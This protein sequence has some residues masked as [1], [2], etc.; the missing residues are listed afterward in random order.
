MAGTEE[1]KA[2]S[3]AEP[4]A[5]R[6][7][8]KLAHR[9]W[10]G[11]VAGLAAVA[12]LAAASCLATIRYSRATGWVT[13]AHLALDRLYDLRLATAL[14]DRHTA[15]FVISGDDSHLAPRAAAQTRILEN[16]AELRDLAR[17]NR[18]V[19]GLLDALAPAIQARIDLDDSLVTS[20]RSHGEEAAAEA[21]RSDRARRVGETLDDRLMLIANAERR[22]ADTHISAEL[23]IGR[24]N[25]IVII[26]GCA[27]ALAAIGS[28]GRFISSALAMLHA[29]I[30]DETNGRE[31]LRRLNETLEERVAE[32][33]AAAEQRALELARSQ[34]ALYRQT[35]LLQSLL[36]SMADAV[37]VCDKQMKLVEINP[38]AERLLGREIRNL[39]LDQWATL[40][41]FLHEENG[42][43]VPYNQWPLVRATRGEDQ[44]AVWLVRIAD[45]MRWLEGSSGPIRDDNGAILGAAIVFRDIT[46]R[47][48][49]AAELRQ[50][51]DLALESARLRS[52]FLTNMSHEIRTPLNGIIGMTQLLLDTK[53]D[54]DQR[55]QLQT[56]WSSG[57]L[58]L[59][60]V[61][62]VLDFSKLAAGKV[63]LEQTPFNLYETVETTVETFAQRAQSQN[64]ELI[65]AI[66]PD[67]PRDAL[68]DARALTQILTNL[69]SNGIKFT[70]SGEVV[71]EVSP[72]ESSDLPGA[73]RF[74]V[75]D[76]GIGIAADARERLF[77]PFSQADGSTSRKFGGSGLGLAITARL[78]EA[79]GGRVNFESELGVGS[80]FTFTIS[81]VARPE[82]APRT[83]TADGLGGLSILLAEANATTRQVLSAR[84]QAWKMKVEAVASHDE[85]LEAIR[86]RLAAGDPYNFIL[87]DAAVLPVDGD[88]L[89]TVMRVALE[90]AR[91][92]ILMMG[93]AAAIRAIDEHEKPVG[94]VDAWIRKPVAPS[95]LCERLQALAPRDERALAE[96]QLT[97][98]LA[99]TQRNGAVLDPKPVRLLVIED[100]PVNLKLALMQ[101]KKLGYH[102]SGA[103]SAREGL[104]LLATKCFP[105]VLM[106]CEM[107]EI[108][109]YAATREIR[110]TEAGTRRTILIAM[111][112]HAIEGARDKC[113]EAG[114]D[115][116][117][118]KPVTLETLRAALERWTP[119]IKHTA[120]DALPLISFDDRESLDPAVLADIRELSSSEDGDA[121]AELVTLFLEDLPPR[122]EKLAAAI[123]DA[124]LD[125]ARAVAHSLKSACNSMGAVRLAAICDQAETSA[126][127]GDSAVVSAVLAQAR[128]EAD[129]VRTLLEAERQRSAA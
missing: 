92:R 95:I 88:D 87:L 43:P 74:A 12:V 82:S 31:T 117:L 42:K 104:E 128:A 55:D 37:L 17:A 102:A 97:G 47:Q 40:F 49:S 39:A 4:F 122:L 120:A 94:D 29:S 33:S 115:D 121:V 76:T 6:P 91:T 110:R 68:G 50:A 60:I 14:M 48:Q 78:I 83:L 71:V 20:R 19:I 85:A 38:A 107:P 53:L 69:V 57:N 2:S 77:D 66:D 16:L 70:E 35:R 13:Q 46:D 106:D 111:T 123:H 41:D 125:A 8:D 108:D 10:A 62:D 112:A 116:F 101:L 109:G 26:F 18:A 52:E 73:L 7:T 27:L 54:D 64:L 105:I 81:L 36:T 89:M 118:S 22:L 30:L 127:E 80:T 119:L 5:A 75:R 98:S 3:H 34:N 32:R 113:L 114:M 11:F 67:V 45:K 25:I 61:N 58:L 99:R 103:K 96:T 129:H 21:L 93:P 9:I 84:L 126:Q 59:S 56:V 63:V 51:R 90:A 44:Q 23:W 28:A 72:A 79:M 24:I 100:N 15:L 65:L 86:L 124:D 1:E